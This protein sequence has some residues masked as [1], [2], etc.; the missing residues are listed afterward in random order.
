MNAPASGHLTGKLVD[1]AGKAI[2]GASAIILQI[3]YDSTTKKQK[4]VLLKGVATKSNGAF[5]FDEL[6]IGKPLVI[7]F[8]NTGYKPVRQQVTLTPPNTEKDLGEIKMEQE[9]EYLSTV[10]VTASSKALKLDLDK[11]VF[12]V[13]KNLV[14]SG[15]T[16]QDVMKNVPGINVDI[17]GNVTLRNSTPVLYIDGR[18][19]TLT[20]DQ[21]PADAIESV[22]IITNPSAKYDASGG[23]A[24]IL[25][26]VLKKNRKTGY[27]G[28]IR[29]GIDKRG[30]INGGG[31][32]NIRQGKFNITSSAMVNQMKARTTGTTVRNNLTTDP[33]TTISQYSHTRENGT[34]LFG[35][36]GFD[37]FLSD[38][39]TLSLSGVR[40]HGEMK[41][42]EVLDTYTDSLFTNGIVSTYSQRNTS[43]MREFNGG[44]LVFGMKQTFKKPGEEWT[45]DANYFSGKMESSANYATD[46]YNSA[47][48]IYNTYLQKATGYGNDQNL[49]LQ[50][51]YTR[52]FGKSVKLE[53]GLRAALRKR[54]NNNQNFTYNPATG[55]Y[56]NV[57][58]ASTYYANTDNVY[59]AYATVSGNIKNFGYKIGLRA[60]S[61]EYNGELKTTGEKFSNKY[62]VSLFPSLFLSQK[63]S[64]NQELQFSITRRINRP[65][66]FNLIPYTDYSDSLNITRGNPGL[67]PEFTTSFE[68]SY[69]KT[70]NNNHSLLASVY[71]KNTTDLITRYIDTA[72][73]PVSGKQDLINTFINANS[74]YTTGLELTST[75]TINKWLDMSTN[76]NIYNSK[77]ETG[78]KTTSQPALWSWFGKYNANVKFL[79]TFTAQ[80][81]ATYQSKTN[82]PV[83]TNSGMGGPPMMQT[84]SA[85]QGYISANWGMDLAVKKT[86]LKN[87]A[88]SV[89]LSVSDIF[90]TRIN[91]QYSESD[92]FTQQYNR[93]RDP[94][95]VR[96][97]FNYRFGKMDAS[98][99]KRLS[100]GTG[101]NAGSSY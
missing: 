98:L 22:E 79:K 64:D 67:K 49:V 4:E 31:D 47:K 13:D 62:P 38:K 44:G 14:S 10:V 27:N 9:Q 51:D 40:V 74:A 90:R 78:D 72:Y 15:G 59:A 41:P 33:L 19:T 63:L 8:S 85:S 5:E 16:A 70:F 23:G 11:K 58:S 28:N 6:P 75:N 29:A 95:M 88:A 53:T 36:L 91:K 68:L 54:E 81:S 97:S 83:N 35:K 101:E 37:Y 69:L 93:L 89:T 76:I 21:I 42:S 94:Q 26:V 87:N 92:Y 17:D 65:N 7:T 46:Y 18:P 56:E 45:F 43:S 100:K 60:E 1:S 20:L 82:L 32:L 71:Y 66:F 24:G 99:F 73:N 52:P 25:N 55:Q 80:L 50:T 77:I 84:M 3:H 30:G 2:N 34:F 57:V 86:F 48:E 12:N 39:T 61:S 96:L